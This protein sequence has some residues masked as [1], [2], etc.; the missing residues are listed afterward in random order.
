MNPIER[1]L[2]VDDEPLSREFLC[3][4][5][6]SRG[7]DVVSASNGADAIALFQESTFD[8]VISDMRMPRADGMEVLS[9]VRKQSPQ[10][11]VILIT[12]FGD[13]T[14]AV[15]AMRGGASDFLLKPFSCDQIDF[16]LDRLQDR[17]RLERENRFL[18]ESH[19]RE[20]MDSGIIGQSEPMRR[21]VD[22][23]RKAARSN[24]TVLV[25]GE[26]GTGK[27]LVSRLIHDQSP[28]ADRP[29]V[30]V[31]CAALPEGL[32]ESELFGHERGAF[33]GAVKR[34]EGR[35]EL[36]DGGTLM[37]DEIGEMPMSLQPKLLRVLEQEEFQRVGGTR[38]MHV[39]VRVI[40]TTNRDLR[41]EI[42]AGRFREDLYFRL[43][44][45]P[46]EVPPLRR[47]RDD[48]PLLAQH[49]L[50]KFRQESGSRVRA[51]SPAALRTLQSYRW[52]GNV[53]ELRNVIHRAIVMDECEVLRPEH[54]M[55]PMDGP[56]ASGG[57]WVEEVVGLRLEDISRDVILAT[58]RHV[59]GNRTAAAGLLGV[60]DRTIRNK[61]RAWREQGLKE[62]E[63]FATASRAS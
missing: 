40:G 22:V 43:Q 55:M 38:T 51:I 3:E 44:V 48:V 37:L 1:V 14:S 13:V 30:R 4:A 31:N 47:R 42:R 10:T 49:F 57:R 27:E 19:I 2:I 9:A 46:I 63:L 12:A 54:L 17:M 36:A 5:I 56:S 61:L 45:M 18:R 7:H 25:T 60:T 15:E 26:S 39:N 41:E 35:F 59:D 33:T 23:S 21:L 24:A 8:L 58:L 50:S 32:L 34:R 16:V 11:P 20:E 53:R 6:G 62:E 29:F 52:P 28:R